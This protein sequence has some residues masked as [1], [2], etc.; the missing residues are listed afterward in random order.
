MFQPDLS[1]P[2]RKKRSGNNLQQP[3]PVPIASLTGIKAEDSV[4]RWYKGRLVVD[5]PGP[6]VEVTTESDAHYVLESMG[7]FGDKS[8]R[9]GDLYRNKARNFA[10]KTNRACAASLNKFVEV[11][12]FEPKIKEINRSTV[13]KKEET[14]E[15]VIEVVD[16]ETIW[17]LTLEESFFLSYALGCL[18]V[19]WQDKELNLD[20]MFDKFYSLDDRFPVRYSVYHHFRVKGWVVRPGEQFGVDYVLYKD[21]PSF[22]HATYSVRIIADNF[23]NLDFTALSGL[24][25]VTESAAKELVLA[26]VSFQR[27]NKTDDDTV[28]AYLKRFIVEETLVRRW[29][30]SIE[31][32]TAEQNQLKASKKL[33]L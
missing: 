33:K 22:Y 1:E 15:E 30:S 5:I 10:A 17:E 9:H 23:P 7:C 11:S 16:S 6:R 27:S 12:D 26:H 20:Q 18:L 8:S 32:E 29:V 2:K 31:R 19:R 28:T 14:S 21:G 13:S 3:F 4:W 25:R 24:N